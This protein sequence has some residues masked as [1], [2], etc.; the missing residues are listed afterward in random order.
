M[1]L[2]GLRRTYGSLRFPR[3]DDPIYVAEQLGHSEPAFS[4]R[5]YARATKRRDRL[6]GSTR[7]AF[8]RAL[9]WAAMG[10][11]GV[12]VPSPA[13]VREEDCSANPALECGKREMELAGLE[14]ATS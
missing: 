1:T 2:H 3:G 7:A 12:E 5:V 4:M 14:P 10:S 8:D 11:S 9:D 13:I 6:S